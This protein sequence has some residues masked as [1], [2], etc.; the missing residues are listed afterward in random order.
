MAA[1]LVVLAEVTDPVGFRDYAAA[2]ADLVARFGGRYLVRGGP[3][4]E[5]L[6]GDWPDARKL[7]ISEWPDLD[8]ARRFWHS[9]EYREVKTLRA[10]KAHVAVRLVDGVAQAP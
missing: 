9:P 7:V 3:G 1:Y 2:A 6:E 10:G 8:T 5:C 4:G